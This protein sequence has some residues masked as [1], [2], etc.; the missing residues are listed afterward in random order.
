[1]YFHS[2]VVGGS[3]WG[4]TLCHLVSGTRRFVGTAYKTTH[5]DVPEDLNPQK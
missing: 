1:M 5:C 4:V 2:G 3:F